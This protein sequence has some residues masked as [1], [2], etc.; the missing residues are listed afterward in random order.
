MPA[1]DS[2]S[3]GELPIGATYAGKRIL[4][5]GTTGFLGKVVLSFLLTRFPSIGRIYVLIRPGPSDRAKDRFE[6]KVMTSPAM[7]PVAAAHPNDLA[8]FVADKVRPLDGNITKD[9]CG[10]SAEALAELQGLDLVLNSAG[11]V[12]FD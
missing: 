12:D 4:L 2:T 9:D 5:S 8:Q 1:H 7:G 6:K 11:L 3:Q 10:L